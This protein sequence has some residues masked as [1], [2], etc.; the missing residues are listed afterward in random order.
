[1]LELIK[2]DPTTDPTIDKIKFSMEESK[3]N[4]DT[5]T[6]YAIEII[7]SDIKHHFNIR[8][9]A[10]GLIRSLSMAGSSI[11]AEV[12]FEVKDIIRIV[13]NI[14]DVMLSFK[15]NNESTNLFSESLFLAITKHEG[16]QS[17]LQ[18]SREHY[19]D[20][21]KERTHSSSISNSFATF[22][23]KQEPRDNDNTNKSKS[24]D[25]P[26]FSQI[27][28]AQT[29]E[30]EKIHT[31]WFDKI[32]FSVIDNQFCITLCNVKEQV[33]AKYQFWIEGITF[34]HKATNPN[35][36]FFL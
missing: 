4:N 29:F 35:T 1:M 11:E 17:I 7:L 12:D 14:S 20:V 5:V 25:L 23:P 18:R 22:K 31:N 6:I 10:H 3:E 13:G 24:N 9:A 19:A 32:R 21:N 36:I 2:A 28:E 33:F 8:G 34:I 16:I 15:E 30:I 27:A 26:H